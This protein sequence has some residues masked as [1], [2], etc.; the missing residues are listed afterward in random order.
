LYKVAS[1][2][3]IVSGLPTSTRRNPI[4]ALEEGRS[5]FNA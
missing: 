2:K 1:L 3:I 5:P 4:E